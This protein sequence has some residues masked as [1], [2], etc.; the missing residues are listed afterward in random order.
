[1]SG[2]NEGTNGAARQGAQNPKCTPEELRARSRANGARSRGPT[3]EAGLEKCR[4]A[5]LTHGLRSQI[6]R[7]LPHED[8]DAIEAKVQWWYDYYQPQSPAA[9][10]M[11]T[12]C[13][14]SDVMINR[15]YAFLAGHLGAQA[16]HVAWDWEASRE[17]RVAGAVEMLATQPREGLARLRSMAHGCR[18]LLKRWSDYQSG[19]ANYGYWPAKAWPE[20]LRVLFGADPHPDQIKDAGPRAYL[21]A[22][23]NIRCLPESEMGED[24]L[25][26]LCAPRR[27]PPALLGKDLPATIPAPA[28][29]R[30]W[31]QN[32]VAKQ[33]EDLTRHEVTLRLGK[34]RAELDSLIERASLPDDDVASRQYLRYHGESCSKFLRSFARLPAEL[35]RAAAGFYDEMAPADGPEE[36]PPDPS[37]PEPEGDPEPQ[38]ARA[39]SPVDSPAGPS[40]AAAAGSSGSAAASHDPPAADEP[41]GAL[42]TKVELTPDEAVT[43][44]DPAVF[45]DGPRPGRAVP[46]VIGIPHVV[47]DHAAPVRTARAGRAEEPGI[48]R[49]RSPPG[50][51][52]PRAAPQSRDGSPLAVP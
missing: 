26:G 18:W 10:L 46:A 45:P 29:C 51:G 15:S 28:A 4:T 27:R 39:D 6:V 52:P 7:P 14:H 47:G 38:P 31:L 8:A 5:R 3:T 20:V 11:T 37:E 30:A 19:L 34:E 49:D 1:M 44:P 24:Q 36:P 33:I 16:R 32:V 23:Y 12:I 50:L 13:A 40:P 43:R 48:P 9:H 2:R 41:G 21:A 42:S 22:L 35:E 25:I 17:R